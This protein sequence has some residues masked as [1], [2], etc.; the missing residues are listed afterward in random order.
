MRK[1]GVLRRWV[2]RVGRV[3]EQECG[4]V[5]C[6]TVVVVYVNFVCHS[7]C[8]VG[9]AISGLDPRIRRPSALI[10]PP[11]RVLDILDFR[12]PFCVLEIP[13]VFN[14]GKKLGARAWDLGVG[15]DQGILRRE[16]VPELRDVGCLS[17]S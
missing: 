12:G 11:Q 17:A 7:V 14:F 4:G 10:V 15:E 9:G 13:G 16:V 8:R 2:C 3:D 1:L 5:S 6:P